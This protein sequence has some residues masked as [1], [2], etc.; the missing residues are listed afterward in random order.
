MTLNREDLLEKIKHAVATVNEA[1][2]A[3]ETA[4]A[5]LVSRS[6]AVGLLLLEAK[7]L[8]PKVA[9]FEA[10]LKNVD[11]LKLSRAYDYLRIAGGRATDEEL[12]QEA[13]DRKRKSRAKKKVPPPV[14]PITAEPEPKP[15]FRD[16]P[17]VTES[18][19]ISIDQRRAENVLLD[20]HNEPELSAE[21]KQ[22]AY[23]RDK[24]VD[25]C[26][27]Y[28]PRITEEDDRDEVIYAWTMAMKDWKARFGE[29]ARA[30]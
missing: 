16:K 7:K 13:R 14:K 5:E 26:R 15:T 12:R 11:G 18:Q 3:A 28:L 23:Y 9:D 20:D 21:Q 6:K 29:K 22:S 30:A 10:F 27:T 24:F 8:H 2:Q 17:H 19:E 1:E 4:K 25:A